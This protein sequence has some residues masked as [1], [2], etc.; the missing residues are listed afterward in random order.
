MKAEETLREI[1]KPAL[2][3]QPTLNQHGHQVQNWKVC[4]MLWYAQG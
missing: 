4:K 2:K 3:A 1:R